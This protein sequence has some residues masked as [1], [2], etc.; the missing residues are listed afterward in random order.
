MAK[1]LN[2]TINLTTKEEDLDP[3]RFSVEMAVLWNRYCPELRFMQFISNFQSW[4]R[5][6]GFYLSNKKTL[7]KMREYCEQ[8]FDGKA[9][10][11]KNG[12]IRS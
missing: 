11:R 6:D 5:N 1:K 12:F 3:S 9:I 2:T 10:L 8:T 7:E 4:L